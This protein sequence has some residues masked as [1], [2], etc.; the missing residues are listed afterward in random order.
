MKPSTRR[1]LAYGSNASLVTII[2]LAVMVLL[3]ALADQ[4][5]HRW[6]LSADARNTL[7]P[8]LLGKLAVLDTDGAP[9][10]IT[11]FTAQSGKPEAY[12]KNRSVAD[13]LAEIDRNSA[14]VQWRQVDFDKERL[15]AEKLGVSQYGQVILQRG[16]AR[17]DIKDRELFKRRG[18][19]SDNQW[20]FLGDAALDRAL[21][22]L[23]TPRRRVVYVLRGHG[24]LDPEEQGADG[25]SALV[26]ALD[27]ERFDV[28]TLDL[29]T[30]TREGEAPSV[31]EDAALVFVARPRGPLSPQEED[32][33]L[34]WIGRGGAVLFAV[35]VGT[36]PPNLLGRMGVSI[37]DGFVLDRELYFPYRD[38]P[39]PRYKSHPIVD[40]LRT[41]DL[42]T[43]LA[44]AA[45]VSVS[46]PP[47]KGVR[48]SPLLVTSRDGWVERGG[49]LLDG[50]AHYEPDLD[51]AG[52]ANYA[53]ALEL[54]SESGLVR[55]GKR[56]ARVVVFG[57]ADVF[58][59]DLIDES[60]GNSVLVVNAVQ[61]LAGDDT[62]LG[63]RVKRGAEV[64]RLALTEEEMGRLRWVSLAL[65]PTLVAGL[66][67][68]RWWS[69][70]GR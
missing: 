48:A 65:M 40:E 44:G 45:P 57:D 16:D 64:R 38:R 8:E 63:V 42:A 15:T 13:L 24:D 11:A 7:S 31:P 61:W 10:T 49:A 14:T 27:Q 68:L 69:R 2:A 21:A 58:T 26:D 56:P 60:T 20:D 12:F 23:L 30:T 3:Y 54:S 36:P 46:E 39:K 6:D 33:L 53:M 28:E 47:P 59:N 51:V 37:G 70:R 62:R 1:L 34:G 35:D 18:K 41:D 50:L 5:R 67:A 17:V 4:Y 52:P 9:V 25:M 19:V 32:V 22:Q 29:M 66:G 43:V 55:D